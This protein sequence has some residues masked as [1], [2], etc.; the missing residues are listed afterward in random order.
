MTSHPSV[1][2]TAM[3]RDGT[4]WY[5]PLALEVLGIADDIEMMAGGLTD[6]DGAELVE[7]VAYTVSH[8]S[9]HYDRLRKIRYGIGGM[10]VWLHPR[11]RAIAVMASMPFLPIEQRYAI[12]TELAGYTRESA[13]E[14]ERAMRDNLGVE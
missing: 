11:H 5:D 1:G 2:T 12:L 9:W 10:E 4:E 3:H 13:E 6:K 7:A 8:M 14:A